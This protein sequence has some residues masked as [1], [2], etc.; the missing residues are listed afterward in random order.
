MKRCKPYHTFLHG[1]QKTL[2]HL[3]SLETATGVYWKRLLGES[4]RWLV[5]I[6]IKKRVLSLILPCSLRSQV[7]QLLSRIPCILRNAKVLRLSFHFSL[8]LQNA[9]FPSVFLLKLCVHFSFL[10]VSS[11]ILTNPRRFKPISGP[12]KGKFWLPTIKKKHMF[13]YAVRAFGSLHHLR[14]HLITHIKIK[15]SG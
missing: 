1:V 14:Y 12:S 11:L 5:Q 8:A 10:P 9:P 15:E 4:Q 7:L 2:P 3:Y 6:T 13:R